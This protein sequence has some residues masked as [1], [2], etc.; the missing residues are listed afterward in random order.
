[1]PQVTL[2]LDSSSDDLT[3]RVERTLAL[4]RRHFTTLAQARGPGAQ[5]PRTPFSRRRSVKRASAAR[6]SV[7][8]TPTAIEATK[9]YFGPMDSS[10]DL[11]A[12]AAPRPPPAGSTLFDRIIAECRGQAY[13]HVLGAFLPKDHPAVVRS[14]ADPSDPASHSLYFGPDGEFNFVKGMVR[15]VGGGDGP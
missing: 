13:D 5:T 11:R 3:E 12:E 1:V 7:E 4:F 14:L 10:V 2:S 6:S 15:G 9:P 8:A